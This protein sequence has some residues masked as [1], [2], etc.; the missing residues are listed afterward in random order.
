MTQA[1]YGGRQARSLDVL[2]QA[3]GDGWDGLEAMF[4]PKEG[5]PVHNQPRD[6]VAAYLARGLNTPL[7]REAIEW[8]MD[9]TMRQP[10][11]ATGKSFE[12]TALLAA[13]R[14]GI[15]GVGEVILAALKRGQDLI[16]Q[17]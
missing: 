11:R 1:A 2:Q 9:I 14:Q 7:G 17:G 13:N 15:E 10:F 6:E 3:T 4:A 16:E 5:A 8:L 12:E